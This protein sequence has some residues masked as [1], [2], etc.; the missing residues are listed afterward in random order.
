MGVKRSYYQ[1][2]RLS[3]IKSASS[4]AFY[5]QS[6]CWVSWWWLRGINKCYYYYYYYYYS[7]FCAKSCGVTIHMKPL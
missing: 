7:T 2:V 5:F 4:L 3:M 6:E 1:E